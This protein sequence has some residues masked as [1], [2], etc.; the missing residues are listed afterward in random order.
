MV[1][2]TDQLPPSTELTREFVIAAHGNLKRVKEMLAANP[3]LVNATYQWTETDS[4]SAIQAAAQV[5][6]TAVVEL[7]IE[8]GAPLEICTAAM[9]GR[10]DEVRHQL[11]ADPAKAKAVGA[12]EIPLMPHAVWS[13]NPQLVK[14][15]YER[16]AKPG[17]DL[18]LHNAILKGNLE[19][20]RWLLENTNPDV[21]S[22]NFQGKTPLTIARELKAEGIIQLLTDHGASN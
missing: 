20:V 11:D 16:D 6:S 22:R 9:L 5:G 1:V 18:A 4:E 13:G 7:L 3:E 2:Q 21:H 19:I 10:Y 8:K 12:H 15:V 17:E 14:L